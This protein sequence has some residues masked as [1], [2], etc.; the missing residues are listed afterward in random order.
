MK[1]SAANMR[2]SHQSNG[3]QVKYVIYHELLHRDYHRHD[4]AFREQEHKFRNY[5]E[6]EYFLDGHMN[7]FEIDEYM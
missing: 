6:C 4:K 7:D 2:A 1:C 5:E 3:H